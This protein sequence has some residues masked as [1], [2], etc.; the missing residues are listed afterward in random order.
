ML[1]CGVIIMVTEEHIQMLT[2]MLP[3]CVE[4]ISP[5]SVFIIGNLK[6]KSKIEPFMKD[7]VIFVDEN[8]IFSG[9]TYNR[10]A[11]IIEERTGQRSR[12][13]WYLQQFLKLAWAYINPDKYYVSL[14]A[15][16]FILRPISFF[17]ETKKYLLTIKTEYHEPYF[18]TINKLF[19]GQINKVVDNSFIAEN[20][21]FDC[22]I[23]KQMLDEI[24]KNT[25]LR[26]EVF[27]EKIL[28]AIDDKDLLKSGFSEFETYGNY[29]LTRFSEMVKLRKLRTMRESLVLLGGN[30]SKEQLEWASAD[31]DVISIESCKYKKTIATSLT[32]QKWFRKCIRMKTFARYRYKVR[33]IYRAI[34]GKEDFTIEEYD[35]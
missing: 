12:A 18:E 8:T 2:K 6:L 9:L 5:K 15:D 7:N 21:I 1:D 30:P 3:Y 11:D 24:E 29:I 14:D 10:I 27:Y 33:K 25:S 17:S 16:T 34:I 4:N 32:S 28:D 35:G 20:M 23:V 13:G 22:E 26:G 19:A 31:Y